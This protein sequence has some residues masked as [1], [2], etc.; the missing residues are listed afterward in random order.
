MAKK[1]SIFFCHV[2]AYLY[3]CIRFVAHYG[4]T[5]HK[6]VATECRR[7][8][9]EPSMFPH[10]RLGKRVRILSEKETTRPFVGLVSERTCK[11]SA[12]KLASNSRGEAVLMKRTFTNVIFWFSNLENLKSNRRFRNRNV[13]GCDLYPISLWYG[14][15]ISR[16]GPTNC[17]SYC[18][19]VSRA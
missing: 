11:S 12:M 16:R 13:H 15:Y 2:F 10:A 6:V 4:R 8:S 14:V 17:L 19:A 3:I 5:L 1:Y 18:E 9:A 7:G